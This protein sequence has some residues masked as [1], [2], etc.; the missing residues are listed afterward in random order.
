MARFS[1][2]V[3]DDFEPFRRLVRIILELE[4][5]FKVV[6]EASDGLGAVQQI[7]KLR[8]DLVL[9]DLGL[10]TLNGIDVARRLRTLAPQTRILFVSAESRA[11]IVQQALHVSDGYVLKLYT[12]EELVPA[13]ELVIRGKQYVSAELMSSARKDL[14][15]DRSSEERFGPGRDF[16]HDVAF[17]PDDGAFVDGLTRFIETALH[18]GD[19]VILVATDSHRSQIVE[20]LQGRSRNLSDAIQN[21][22]YLSLDSIDALSLFMVSDWPD[23]IRFSEVVGDLMKGATQSASEQGRRVAAC[24]ELA[25]ILW[26]QGLRGAA[27]QVEK[28]WDEIARTYRVDTLCG[29]VSTTLDR[30]MYRQEFNHICAAHSAVYFR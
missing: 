23:Q 6:G 9:L 2:L 28:M 15:K 21:R 18:D 27:I 8:P 14:E 26:A 25:P 29:Y 11:D 12:A 3:V 1:V 22:S 5:K 7:T 19:V 10:P 24:G 20:K 17:Y 13:I 16:R 30:D 4:A